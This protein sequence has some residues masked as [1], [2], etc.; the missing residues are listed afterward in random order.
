MRR[1]AALVLLASAA[2]CVAL[3]PLF[4]EFV[5]PRLVANTLAGE[6]AYR[7]TV[8]QADNATVV[9]DPNG[10]GKGK[11][12]IVR[13]VRPDAGA[14][15]DGTVVW[16]ISLTVTDSAGTVV[17][18]I[19]ERYAFDAVTQNPDDCCAESVDGKPAAHVGVRYKWP[20]FVQKRGY[21][22]FDPQTGT[23]ATIHYK[24]TETLDG[25][26][27]YRFEHEVPWTRAGI[28]RLPGG[29]N[30]AEIEA[31]GMER[32]FTGTRS[33]LVE[34]VTGLPVY[35]EERRTEELRTPNP[36]DPA[37]PGR[38]VLFD[39][40]V[41]MT[42]ES[43]D[44]LVADAREQKSWLLLVHDRL[45][46]GLVVA[47]VLLFLTALLTEYLGRRKAGDADGGI[48]DP[49]AEADPSPDQV[50][51]AEVDFDPAEPA[52]DDTLTLSAA[53]RADDG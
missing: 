38:F 17:T 47:G 32:W 13:T 15:D 8:S 21:N 46:L 12:T 31:A 20:Y 33:I 41:K 51:A 7:V 42:A 26:T 40:H 3:A 53:T 39:G 30:P 22:Y 48:R 34:P 45:P 43:S 4:R 37:N 10:P 23:A 11:A 35:A 18:R 44:E 29:V 52:H 1:R 27:V 9:G 14:G 49:A 25:L 6:D 28:P 16:D 19:P 24:G 36:D 2:F 50:P 5:F